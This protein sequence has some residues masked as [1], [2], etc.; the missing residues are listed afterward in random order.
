MNSTPTFFINTHE[1][2]DKTFYYIIGVYY[3]LFVIIIYRSINVYTKNWLSV[4]HF[5]CAPK[6]SCTE[7]GKK[8]LSR[9]TPPSFCAKKGTGLNN[10][11][12]G[13]K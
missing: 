6:K 7:R 11:Q 8:D 13:Q 5:Q 3:L 10:Q 1:E 9:E 2:E 12:Q 4:S